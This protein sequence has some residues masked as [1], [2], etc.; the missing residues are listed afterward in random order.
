MNIELLFGKIMWTDLLNG[1]K[2][3]P[4]HG[5]NKSKVEGKKWAWAK[6]S[7]LKSLKWYRIVPLRIFEST[8]HKVSNGDKTDLCLNNNSN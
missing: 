5:V 4:M 7:I 2:T 8:E 1:T 6:D 3:Q